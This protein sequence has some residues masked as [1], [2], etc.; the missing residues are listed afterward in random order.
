MN[1][2]ETFM[3]LK[4]NSKY[5]RKSPLKAVLLLAVIDMY[6]TG[7]LSS[8]E[9]VYN[10]ALKDNF[11]RVWNSLLSDAMPEAYTAFW[12]LQ[13]EEF[14]HIVHKKHEEH[15]LD[16]MQDD[17]ISP[18]EEKILEC[19]R[20]AELDNDLYF[21]MTLQ[22]GRNSLRRALLESYFDFSENEI[23]RLCSNDKKVQQN[24][25]EKAISE[26]KEF[27]AANKST[28]MSS[29]DN[30]NKTSPQERFQALPIDIQILFNYEYYSF[31]KKHRT[32]R[33]EILKMC[34]TIYDLYDKVMTHHVMHDELSLMTEYAYES[35]LKDLK[36]SL[37]I[38]DD[39]MDIIDAIT[40]ALEDLTG[41]PED[42]ISNDEIEVIE[43]DSIPANDSNID[44]VEP[45]SKADY[46]VKNEY[47]MGYVLDRY[48]E[49]VYSTDG[50]LKILNGR[51][52][53]FNYKYVCLTVKEI[54]HK[55]GS[56]N[57]SGKRLVAYSTSDLFELLDPNSYIDSIEDFKEG[58]DITD[59]QIKFN[60][61]W[62]NYYGTNIERAAKPAQAPEPVKTFTSTRWTIK[63][64]RDLQLLYKQGM[65]V[66]QL[67][68][69]FEKD[70]ES[71]LKRLT[72]KGL[73]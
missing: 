66:Q 34:P 49:Q 7:E 61:V 55:D 5:G 44:I 60:G 68:T 32:E 65:T 70:I 28:R 59:N 46:T 67:A 47:G 39:A 23:D 22:S 24:Q 26:Y 31:L 15:V 41:G 9:I 4:N 21:L 56:W 13:K 27:L 43:E 6:E 58:D 25:S 52:Y 40:S 19:V 62:Y 35:L 37:M 16:L 64:D 38:E 14:W 50:L 30:S 72:L 51:I 29:I 48:G 3:N 8:N 11:A 63:Q 54:V 71:V 53:R 20:F 57:K 10:D 33:D 18:S 12:Y 2:I 45:K 36:I 17:R 73:T 1:Y 42:V 69:Y